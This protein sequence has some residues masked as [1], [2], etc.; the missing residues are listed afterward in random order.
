M[1]D[2]VYGQGRV[3][4][5][6]GNVKPSETR[7]TPWVK[8]REKKSG[9]GNA[10]HGLVLFLFYFFPSV[11]CKLGGSKKVCLIIGK[12]ITNRSERAHAPITENQ[13]MEG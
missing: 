10:S 8:E 1:A 11:V 2:I 12:V 4:V 9:Q 7:K 3:A 5:T 6:G 13:P